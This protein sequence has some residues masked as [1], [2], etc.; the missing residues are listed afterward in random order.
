MNPFEY[1]AKTLE[2]NV[3]NW[4]KMYPK[5][6]DKKSASPFTKIRIILMNG[7]EFES[8]WFLHQFSRNCNDADL[9]REIAFI[10]NQEQQQQ[11]RIGALKPLDENFLETTIGYEQLAIE[12]TAILAQNETD[13]NNLDALNLALLEDFDHLYRFANLLKKDFG[14]EAET[15]VGKLTEI[16]PGRPTINEHRHPRD[17]V[18]RH[19]DAKTAAPYSK[20]VASIITAA[21]QQTMNWYMNIAQIYHNDIGRKLFAEIGMV[22]EMHVSQYES[23]KDP[24]CTWLENWL[25]H[26]YTECYLYYSMMQDETDPHIKK[27]WEEHF[28]MEV[29]HLKHVAKL[30]EKYEKKK[31]S[32]V[33]PNPE[34]PRLLKFGENKEYIRRVL[35]DT[36]WITSDRENYIDARKLTANAD[37]FKYNKAV[38]DSPDD[39]A[40]HQII[41]EAIK[42]RGFGGKDYRYQESDHPIDALNDRKTDNVTI[43]KE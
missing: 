37:F 43:G 2:D 7:T 4:K 9:K 20:L 16:M 30:L 22:E 3:L 1:P 8:T 18:K 42:T 23:L 17:F 10:R 27:I 14:I 35:K 13:K 32:G 12:L 28:Q 33:I 40:S 26:E 11:K 29:S 41:K 34:F 36:V 15:L 39:V 6:Y 24:N 19:L 38:N 5:P 25:M 31:V 21:E